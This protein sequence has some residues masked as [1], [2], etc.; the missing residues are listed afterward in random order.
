MPGNV[1]PE[2][3]PNSATQ[4]VSC[5]VF[6]ATRAARG[7]LATGEGARLQP[8]MNAWR[9]RVRQEHPADGGVQATAERVSAIQRENSPEQIRVGSEYCAAHAPQ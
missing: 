9:L 1:P 8:A 4:S 6:I 7:D 2:I 5:Y 3:R